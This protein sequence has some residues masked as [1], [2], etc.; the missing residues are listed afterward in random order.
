MKV[1]NH[2]VRN[3]TRAGRDPAGKFPPHDDRRAAPLSLEMGESLRNVALAGLR[4]RRPELTARELS[5][6]LMRVMYG[7]VPQ[8]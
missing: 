5:R 3:P 7:F 6:E 1:S 2:A 8:S 4:I